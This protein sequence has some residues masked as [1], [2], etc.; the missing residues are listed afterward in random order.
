MTYRRLPAPATA[1]AIAELAQDIVG[2]R[3]LTLDYFAERGD[4]GT[5][6]M[7]FMPIV[8]GALDGYSKKQF[9][10]LMVF[11]VDGRDHAMPVG[12]NGFPMFSSCRIWRRACYGKAWHKAQEALQVLRPPASGP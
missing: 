11:A 6:R 3:V 10:R 8:M 12:M 9:G 1:E 2:G 7:V 5:A 4:A